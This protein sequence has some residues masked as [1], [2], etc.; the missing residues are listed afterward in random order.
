M[1][2][3]RKHF[4]VSSLELE[5]GMHRADQIISCARKPAGWVKKT[6]LIDNGCFGYDQLR[7]ILLIL[8]HAGRAVVDAGLEA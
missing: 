5:H 8:L 3:A 4:R 1:F 6:A 7:T 2:L